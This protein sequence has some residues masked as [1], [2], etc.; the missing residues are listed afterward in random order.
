MYVRTG[1]EYVHVLCPRAI[2]KEWWYVYIM[3]NG[4]IGTS[5]L[6]GTTWCMVLQK[7]QH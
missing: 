2:D 6:S 5:M 1:I 4:T 7:D 3:G